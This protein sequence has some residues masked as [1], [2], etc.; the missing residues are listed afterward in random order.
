MLAI[1]T[2]GIGP[3]DISQG[4]RSKGTSKEEE[5]AIDAFASLMDMVATQQDMTEFQDASVD[6]DSITVSDVSKQSDYESYMKDK[7][8]NTGKVEEEIKTDITKDTSDTEVNTVA[9]TD[10]KED[11][12]SASKLLREVRDMLKEEL[13]I[14]DEELDNLLE[15]M[16]LAVQDLLVDGNL[17]N[18]ILQFKNAG[19]VD[20]LINEDL[21]KLLNQV[22][23]KLNKIMADFGITDVGDIT[24]FVDFVNANQEEIAQYI[25]LNQS[26]DSTDEGVLQVAEETHEEQDT[27]ADDITSKPD[28]R[29][30]QVN[31]DA[32]TLESKII[33]ES[34]GDNARQ[35]TSNNDH[36]NAQI[37]TSLS[38][39]ID[40]AVSV[41]NV[42]VS[43]FV[44]SVQEADIIRQIID[45]IKVTVS[46]DVKSMEL[47]L[48]PE[49]LGKVQI[50][51]AAKD[52]AMSAQIIAETEAA[53][54]AIENNMAVLKEAFNNNDLKVEAVEVMV[55]S[56]GYFDQPHD[57]QFDEKQ[58]GNSV[59]DKKGSINLNS[60]DDDVELSESEELQVEMMKSQGNRVSYLA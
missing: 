54:Q 34:S 11:I 25:E 20:I 29:E 46:K 6:M 16:G 4:T 44:D 52:G 30:T 14:T 50:N 57:G 35:S 42:D 28:N 7:Y 9:T 53:K 18:F 60:L 40:N 39:A 32:Q 59:A 38:Q 49:H 21:A 47:Q 56:Y 23:S 43:A 27:M 31:S 5:K 33:T 15:T 3:M 10:T 55:A 48:N 41:N 12:T 58:Q 51:V 2:S 37:A 45:K 24:E 22:T 19:E 13:G 17:K 1:S 36:S 26:S 8:S